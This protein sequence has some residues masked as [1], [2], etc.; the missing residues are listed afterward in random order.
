MWLV[1]TT[2]DKSTGISDTTQLAIM[3]RMVF[4]DFTVKDL[5][6]I[7]THESTNNKEGYQ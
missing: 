6:E 1:F 3:R 7:I 2:I 4:S 5:H